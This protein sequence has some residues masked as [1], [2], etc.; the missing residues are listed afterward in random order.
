MPVDVKKLKK[1]PVEFCYTRI[2]G[3]TMANVF[4]EFLR[5]RSGFAFT[6]R[7]VVEVLN[8]NLIP[9][10]SKWNPNSMYTSIDVAKKKGVL[11]N[12]KQKG[13][14]YWY[15]EDDSDATHSK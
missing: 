3:T 14:Y 5:S 7:E 6:S 15:E 9:G 2:K 1:L 12:V 11:V 8:E 10:E 13:S 4:I